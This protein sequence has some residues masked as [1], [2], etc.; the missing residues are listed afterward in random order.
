[1]T[2]LVIVVDEIRIYE[3]LSTRTKNLKLKVY[4]KSPTY[5]DP[6]LQVLGHARQCMFDWIFVIY[7]TCYIAP[8]HSQDILLVEYRNIV[9][10]TRFFHLL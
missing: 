10:S 4:K 9:R 1:V 5:T 3:E 2:N 6:L 8:L 7:I